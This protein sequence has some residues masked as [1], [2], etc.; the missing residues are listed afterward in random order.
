MNDLTKNQLIFIDGGNVPTA[1]YMDS[2]VIKANARAA[3]A[4]FSFVRG[5]I[6]GFFN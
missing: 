1:Y 4:F 5:V 2:D 3:D 6:E